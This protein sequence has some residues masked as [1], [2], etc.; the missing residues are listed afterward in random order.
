VK[1]L[2]QKIGV[3]PEQRLDGCVS[4]G[5]ATDE[6]HRCPHCGVAGIAGAY[7]ILRVIAEGGHG[8]MYLAEDASGK[9]VALKE[10]VF[11]KVP[12]LHTL[13][14]FRREA[15]ILRQLDHPQIPKFVA[16]FESGSGVGTRLYIAQEFVEG[17]SLE[18]GI[19]NH[20]FDE[21][22]IRG[23]ACQILEV[24]V[25]LQR[26]TPKVI[27]RDVKPANVI[28]RPDGSISLVDFGAA[29]G[30]AGTLGATV[31]VGTYGYM[32]PEQLG[33]EVDDTSDV[34]ALGATL[35]HL[36]T[37]RS[38]REFLGGNRAASVC[39]GLTVSSGL[40]HWLERAV[41][42][43]PDERFANARLA[44]E[45]LQP[46]LPVAPTKTNA[47]AKPGVFGDAALA[48]LFRS[49]PVATTRS[50]RAARFSVFATLA[51]GVAMVMSAGAIK[52]L[53]AS[54]DGAVAPAVVR[55]ATMG[56]HAEAIDLEGVVIDGR[57][58]PATS[59]L[60]I[61]GLKELPNW[62]A[63]S[64]RMSPSELRQAEEIDKH[65]AT[66]YHNMKALLV[67][68]ERFH[69]RTGRYLFFKH[70]DES[71]WK[72]LDLKLPAAMEH[73]YSARK[74]PQGNLILLA[75]ANLD[76]DPFLDRWHLDTADEGDSPRQDSSDAIDQ[77]LDDGPQPYWATSPTGK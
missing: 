64:A 62:K 76:G 27:H 48:E 57:E 51:L 7:R 29:R 13:E 49:S 4:C 63:L 30:A 41:S 6:T 38:P 32:P 8:R 67:A 35:L 47:K 40:R 36:L 3:R 53:D 59:D 11:A 71:T 33:G 65:S 77:N 72:S 56:K 58:S 74:G 46:V 70:G 73:V 44:L 45:A 19:A 15:E 26:L 66:A 21:T 24:L 39:Q 31:D 10:L 28:V 75:E 54:H 22:E 1:A 20:R 16:S 25:Y 14:A 34:Y 2:E 68:E 43:R 52:L 50:R 5:S 60:G 42:L 61:S 9:Q 23:L 12:D 37:H 18:K 17:E 55:E 69:A